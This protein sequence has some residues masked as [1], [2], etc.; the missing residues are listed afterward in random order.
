MIQQSH[1]HSQRATTIIVTGASSGI[2]RD[3]AIALSKRGNVVVAI[4]R[5]R[6]RL[7][8]LAADHERIDIRVADIGL[9]GSLGSLVDDILARHGR[10]DG[11]I[12][13]AAIQIDRRMDD[14]SY[15]DAEIASEIEINLTAPMVLARRL[16][17]HLQARTRAVV[18]NLTSGLAFVPKR[19]AA[20]YSASKAGLHLFSEGLRVQ[21]RGS[22]VR[23]VEAVMPLV[24]TPMTSGRGRGKISSEDAA[25]AVVAGLW[26]GPETL[27][28]GKARLLPP[29]LRLAPGIAARILQRN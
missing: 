18:V 29:M 21:L 13:N 25:G 24:D 16:L 9:I 2:G 17:P 4:G 12:N 20:V 5:D 14:A 27:Y 10:I 15:L 11:L 6:D 3:I 1:A 19:S 8:R 22:N 7:E 23:V 28:V 26:T